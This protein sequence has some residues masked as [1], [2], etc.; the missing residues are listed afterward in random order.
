MQAARDW[1]Y[2]PLG[3]WKVKDRYH[4][5]AFLAIEALRVYESS[6]CRGCGQSAL[7]TH[8]PFNTPHFGVEESVCVGCEHLE[9]LAKLDKPED[10][11]PGTKRF[12]VNRMERKAPA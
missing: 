6:L 7:L 4:P 1:G 10:V 2:P 3:P 8:D 12:V 11:W 5:R 9:G